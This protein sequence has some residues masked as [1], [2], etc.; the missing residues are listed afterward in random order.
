M[1][2]IE[3]FLALLESVTPIVRSIKHA[4][5][6][7][8]LVGGSVRDLILNQPLKDFD[9][10][11]H[12]L[13]Q[14]QLEAALA[15]HG[16]VMLIGKKFGV[17]KIAGMEADWSLPRK[18]SIGR[19]PTVA[20]DPS[21]TIQEA[22]RRRDLTM[23]AMAINLNDVVDNH[24]LLSQ[25]KNSATAEPAAA[26]AIIDPYGGLQ[27]MAA[28]R[29]RAVDETL[30]IQDPLRFFRVMQF[31]GRFGM[32]PDAALNHLCAT[33]DLHDQA[34]NAPLA[35]ERIH[36]EMKKL[37]L[38]SPSPSYG[39][40]WLV[41]INRLNEIFPEIHALI[42]VNQ[43]PQHHPEG[44][45]FE[46]TMQ[47]IDAAARI[48]TFQSNDEKL[49]VVMSAL[50]HDLGK[51]ATT[52]E[53]GRAIGHETVGIPITKTLLH[54]MTNDHAL[55]KAVT[56]MVR[57]HLLP[58]IFLDQKSSLKAYKR[59]ALKLAPEVT[60]RHI[61]LLSLAD[62][63]ACNPKGHAPLEVA[64]DKLE[65]FMQKTEQATVTHG[66]EAPVLLGRHL[67]DTVP[68]GPELG[69]LLKEAYLIQIDEGI[70]DWEELK[71]RVLT[72]RTS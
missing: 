12:H 70:T 3:S 38:K 58:F 29:L 40:R 15:K 6:I 63:Q 5:G 50:C 67:L 11:V 16:S 26:V 54:R 57:Y 41:A 23:N 7:A 30:F 14:E 61:G 62:N 24:V 34:T 20:I 31:I 42:G 72:T 18:D 37:L 9:I 25:L 46:H 8:Y 4:G 48:K 21:M 13:T 36:E 65:Q 39:F 69:K 51:P 45:V 43:P 52:D 2:S 60:M 32:E 56:K 22:C 1:Q 66:P 27:D 64:Y 17:F 44:D 49:M 71:R 35:Q 53:Q 55:I 10:E 19:K 28:K 59:L 33:M 68:P 47:A